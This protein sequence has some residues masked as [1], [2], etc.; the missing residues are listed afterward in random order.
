MENRIEVEGLRKT[1]RLYGRKSHRLREM[2]LGEQGLSREFEALKGISF[3]V[4]EGECVGIIGLN[5]SGKSTLLKL[6]SGVASPTKGSIRIRGE[7]E[8]LLELGAGFRPEDTGIKNVER[9]LI[10]RGLLPAER[11]TR[12]KEILAFA[13][14]GDFAGQPV[15]T[16]STGMFVRLA[17]AAALSVE[18]QILLID[19]A[20]SVGDVFF[21]EKCF[22]RI[23]KLSGRATVLMVSHD[24]ATIS[25]FCR[26]TILL[27]GGVLVYDGETKDAIAEYYRIR[28]GT[29]PFP[30]KSLGRKAAANEAGMRLPKEDQLSGAGE[31]RITAYA[32]QVNGTAFMEEVKEGDR[33]LVSLAV[34]APAPT[35][36]LIAGFQVL[37]KRGMEVFG[38]TNL[39]S[40]EG[41]FATRLPA[42]ESFITYHFTWPEI[43]EG[44]YFMT[45]GLGTGREVLCQTEQCWVNQAVHFSNSTSRKLIYG[46]FNRKMEDF[47]IL[48]M[49]DEE[50][51]E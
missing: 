22:R 3:T 34:Q 14:I 31:I 30:E 32:W 28:Q 12:M 40:R 21:Q 5:G 29:L 16:Y 26:R 47:Q 19:E 9:Q 46:L 7:V 42:G 2:L 48:A 20:L 25:R 18:P 37:D 36:S 45:L 10:M 49:E 27:N 51:H 6:L 44:D 39:T 50:K 24:L 17:F 33:I 8:A 43:R 38:E 23:K 13:G 11:K 35:D 41:G 1:Y 15:R 4:A